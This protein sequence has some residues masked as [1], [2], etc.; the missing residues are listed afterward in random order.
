MK[1]ENKRRVRSVLALGLAGILA[2]PNMNWSIFANAT[3]NAEESVY[4]FF[5]DRMI[6]TTE[7]VEYSINQVAEEN[8]VMTS[9]L[10]PELYSVNLE[11]NW[12]T[13]K[14]EDGNELYRY[15]ASAAWEV[16]S[17][18][19]DIEY[20][21]STGIYKMWRSFVA[22]KAPGATFDWRDKII[23][24]TNINNISYDTG[25]YQPQGIMR[26]K[27]S[28]IVCYYESKNGVDWYRPQN[29]KQFYYQK[30]DGTIVPTNIVAYGPFGSSV[31]I[32]TNP[33]TNEPRYLSASIAKDGESAQWDNGA[34][35]AAMNAAMGGGVELS[36]SYDGIYWE[37]GITICDYDY[38]DLF[39]QGDTENTLDWSKELN[40][41]V[42]T[43][44]STPLAGDNQGNRGVVQMSSIGLDSITDL[45]TLKEQAV[46]EAGADGYIDIMEQYWTT[47]KVVLTGDDN[48]SQPYY[49]TVDCYEEGYYIGTTSMLDEVETSDRYG[50]MDGELIWSPDLE[51]WYYMDKGNPI[52][53][54]SNSL[55]TVDE[56]GS[57]LTW[58]NEYGMVYPKT[59]IDSGEGLQL[60]YSATAEIHAHKSSD[61]KKYDPE[62]Y[63]IVEDVYSENIADGTQVVQTGAMKYAN[64]NYDAF[65][66]YSVADG[67]ESG[68][69]TTTL[70]KVTGDTL[71]V[72]ASDPTKIGVAV[73]DQDGNVVSG[74]GSG[75]LDEENKDHRNRCAVVWEGHSLSELKDGTY[76]FRITISGDAVAYAIAGHIEDQEKTL[77]VDSETITFYELGKTKYI[78]ANA[79]PYAK[80]TYSVSEEDKNVVTVDDEGFVTSVGVGN[81]TISVTTEDGRSKT[82]NVTVNN[83]ASE[84]SRTGLWSLRSDTFSLNHYMSKCTKGFEHRYISLYT[85]VVNA[86]KAGTVLEIGYK[87]QSTDSK[88]FWFEATLNADALAAA[89]GDA[90]KRIGAST[91]RDDYYT[92]TNDQMRWSHDDDYSIVQITYEA[93][94][95]VLENNWERSRYHLGWSSSGVAEIYYV[96]V[97]T[98]TDYADRTNLYDL[99]NVVTVD[100]PGISSFELTE[101]MSKSLEWGSV[102]EISYDSSTEMT[103]CDSQGNGIGTPIHNGSKD[104]IQITYEELNT[105]LPSGWNN[106]GQN[107]YY[108]AGDDC[109][110]YSAKIGVKAGYREGLWN[111]TD[112]YMVPESAYSKNLRTTTV[113]LTED[114]VNTLKDGAVLEVGYTSKRTDANGSVQLKLDVNETYQKRCTTPANCEIGQCNQSDTYKHTY[115]YVGLGSGNWNGQ[116]LQVGD[117]ELRYNNV[118]RSMDSTYTGAFMANPTSEGSVVQITYEALDKYL[119]EDWETVGNTAIKLY[120]AN[121]QVDYNVHYMC[122]GT[123]GAKVELSGTDLTLDAVKAEGANVTVCVDVP[124]EACQPYVSD[125]V[126]LGDSAEIILDGKKYNAR[127]YITGTNKLEFRITVETESAASKLA[128][129]VFEVIVPENLSCAMDWNGKF[130]VCITE[131][132]RWQNTKRDG[133]WN[134]KTYNADADYYYI[135][136]A[137]MSGVV[138]SGQNNFWLRLA[139]ILQGDNVSWIPT[140]QSNA[141][142]MTSIIGNNM[143]VDGVATNQS[144]N[145]FNG[146]SLLW[147][148]GDAIFLRI[149]YRRNTMNSWQNDM[150]SVKIYSGTETE[151]VTE[152]GTKVIVFKGDVD[153]CRNAAGAPVVAERLDEIRYNSSFYGSYVASVNYPDS[154]TVNGNAV[155]DSSLIPTGDH[156]VIVNSYLGNTIQN[157]V[158]FTEGDAN[159]DGEVTVA[160][161]IAEKKLAKGTATT[162]SNGH[163]LAADVAPSEFTFNDDDVS[164]LRKNLVGAQDR[165]NL[166]ELENTASAE[167]ITDITTTY[168]EGNFVITEAMAERLSSGA[169]IEVGYEYAKENNDW[170]W[171]KT[172]WF[173]ARNGSDYYQVGFGGSGSDAV[174]VDE[175]RWNNSGNSVQITYDTLSRYM[176]SGWDAAG[177]VITVKS[178][179]PCKIKYVKVGTVPVVEDEPVEDRSNLYALTDTIEVLS[180]DKNISAAYAGGGITIDNEMLSKLVPGSVIEI[181][182]TC[183]ATETWLGNKN[184]WFGGTCKDGQYH[185]IGYKDSEG[186]AT[187]LPDSLKWND[188]GT[189]VQITYEQLNES[190]ADGWNVLWGWIGYSAAGPCTIHSIKIGQQVK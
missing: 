23:D 147:K 148:D 12:E 150:K 19:F 47:P 11:E 21:E 30:Q 158:Y 52:L 48:Y 129:E 154:I 160:D 96:R 175:L 136:S 162:S 89:G 99:E 107:I 127:L 190:L 22:M 151:G 153:V 98:R 183:K 141:L 131:G 32:N 132:A 43:T 1:R 3:D 84:H 83:Y 163:K 165:T 37:G 159:A 130:T 78:G 76:S 167:T 58:G 146:S 10:T 108:K 157:M 185:K 138:L 34:V 81:A 40:A 54:S 56:S 174:A 74:F 18:A 38:G 181:A 29:L 142:N 82:V 65:A 55:P 6:S 69:I 152:D 4:F 25:T 189:I 73:I 140:E 75:T 7:N 166:S 86:L 133:V 88:N 15:D 135:D 125:D 31:S 70:F 92:M 176:P 17:A 13:V 117:D 66:G 51:T 62:L 94:N 60:F 106:V 9:F 41:Y 170:I 177:Q 102:V 39:M 16:R 14:D 77:E 115:R 168:G 118:S 172:L 155:D 104:V 2:W 67:Q 182:Y 109:I 184:F 20:D 63:A 180:F 179:S 93:L 114:M 79:V 123:R 103:F 143:L 53:P 97:G 134:R 188:S 144:E 28:M 87:S 156:E 68:N 45:V 145:V 120:A 128:R 137:R 101:E 49:A 85:D 61:I 59:I 111:L 100:N 36:W 91:N 124:E 139:N 26:G 186:G 24:N 173:V 35:A 50:K 110:I 116:W 161:I 8:K 122:I 72:S 105:A 33:D 169:V 113:T 187:Y 64:L 112:K 95:E 5:D 57:H 27:S 149:F 71:R 126:L 164:V 90:W 44:R 42:I 46:A 80:I 119:P 121:S 171:N 178:G